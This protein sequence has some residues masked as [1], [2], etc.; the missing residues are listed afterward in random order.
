MNRPVLFLAWTSTSGR[1]QDIANAL[2]GEAA[3]IY[4]RIPY[5]RH[6]WSTVVRY[7]VS[8]VLTVSTLVRVRPRAVIVTN[9]PLIPPLIVAI[10]AA[11]ARRPF[12]LDSHP[13]GFGRKGRAVLARL[14]GVHRVLARRARA[15]LVTTALVAE[16]VDRWG[17]NGIVVHEA[18]VDFPMAQPPTDPRVLFVGIFA[19]DEPVAAVVEAAT[20]LPHVTFQIT[21]SVD[22]APRGL[23]DTSPSN[24]AYVGFLDQPAYRAAVATCSLVL[25]LTTEPSSVMRSGYEAIYAGVPLVVTDTEALRETFPSAGFCDNTGPSIAAAVTSVLT[26]PATETATR[27]RAALAL[28]RDRWQGQLAALTAACLP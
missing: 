11:V 26:S 20:L 16:Q 23:I 25:T 27:S 3:V 18:P 7:A 17:A 15:V 4:P 24:V 22:R 12:V 13:T 9:P 8:S 28:Q 1:A 6:P 19:S 10:W 21:G 2:G 5:L 14:Q